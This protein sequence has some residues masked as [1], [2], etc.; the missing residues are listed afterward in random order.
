MLP[1]AFM[2]LFTPGAVILDVTLRRE[3]MVRRWTITSEPPDGWSCRFVDAN[4]VTVSG[5]AT[6][7]AVTVKTREW[8]AEIEAARADGWI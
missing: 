7:D 4:S 5:C 8:R 6:V 1:Y 3:A 2:T